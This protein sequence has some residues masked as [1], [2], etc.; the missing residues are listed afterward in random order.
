MCRC[1][2]LWVHPSWCLHGQEPACKPSLSDVHVHGYTQPLWKQPAAT[3][4]Q[5]AVLGTEGPI[6]CKHRPAAP[7]CM[8][9]AGI[10]RQELKMKHSCMARPS[11]AL[12][13]P[14]TNCSSQA[15]EVKHGF[16]PKIKSLASIYPQQLKF[17]T[18]KLQSG[19][20]LKCNSE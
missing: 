4:A 9:P 14:F 13:M 11:Q 20:I 7:V 3:A 18:K 6:L 12:L 10:H 17:G 5:Q 16:C 19:P 1:S 8:A 2:S 15:S